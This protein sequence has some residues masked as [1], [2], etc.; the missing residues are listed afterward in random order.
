LEQIQKKYKDLDEDDVKEKMDAVAVIQRNPWIRPSKVR[1]KKG[2]EV[3]MAYLAV[4][5]SSNVN[6]VAA[7]HSD[8]IKETIF[9]NFIPEFDEGKF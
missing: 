4:V 2:L 6:G 8:I 3:N 5:G 1:P 9:N 7:I